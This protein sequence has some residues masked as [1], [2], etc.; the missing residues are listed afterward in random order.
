[1][2]NLPGGYSLSLAQIAPL[3]PAPK[4][5][6]MLL[7]LAVVIIAAILWLIKD[8]KNSG[9]KTIRKASTAELAKNLYRRLEARP[10]RNASTMLALAQYAKE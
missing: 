1:M 8:K 3:A 4:P 5:R 10:R 9:P 6:W 7:L 2:G